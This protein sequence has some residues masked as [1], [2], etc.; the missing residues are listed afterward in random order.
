MT[1]Q[2]ALAFAVMEAAAY[3]AKQYWDAMFTR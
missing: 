1:W 3:F 2:I